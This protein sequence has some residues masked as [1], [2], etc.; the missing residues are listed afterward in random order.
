MHAHGY[1]HA[2]TIFSTS[3]EQSKQN[4]YCMSRLQNCMYNHATNQLQNCMYNQPTNYK[5]CMYK[6]DQL[7]EKTFFTRFSHYGWY[8][9]YGCVQMTFHF[10]KAAINFQHN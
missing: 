5:N 1:S 6:G 4:N 10:T 9:N 8:N 7:C 2:V 3:W